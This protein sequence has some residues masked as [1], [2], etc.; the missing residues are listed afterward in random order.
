MELGSVLWA[1]EHFAKEINSTTKS[2]ISF[3]SVCRCELKFE[4]SEKVTGG[5]IVNTRE[6]SPLK[7]KV[8]EK[9]AEVHKMTH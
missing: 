9:A 8:L 4:Q 3:V 2:R 1:I 6:K 7:L 5:E